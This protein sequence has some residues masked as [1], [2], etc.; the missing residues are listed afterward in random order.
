MC[1]MVFAGEV[2]SAGQRCNPLLLCYMWILFL[3]SVSLERPCE[4]FWAIWTRFL[5]TESLL[6]RDSRPRCTFLLSMNP[7]E[8]SSVATEWCLDEVCLDAPFWMTRA[9]ILWNCASIKRAMN[10]GQFD[11]IF[12][13]LPAGYIS[14]GTLFPRSLV[15]LCNICHLV[16]QVCVVGSREP[17]VQVYSSKNT[18]SIVR[19]CFHS[20]FEGFSWNEE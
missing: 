11:L 6:H 2:F 1:D 16:H 17:H 8:D 18:I 9:L 7:V 4:D 15:I 10:Q 14:R 5:L 13:I 3:Q 20:C 19:I 12:L